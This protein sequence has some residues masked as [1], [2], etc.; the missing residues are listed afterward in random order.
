MQISDPLE[1]LIEC[2]QAEVYPCTSARLLLDVGWLV[3]PIDADAVQ[4]IDVVRPD[5]SVLGP[6]EFL[7]VSMQCRYSKTQSQAQAQAQA[8]ARALDQ[9]ILQ[10]VVPEAVLDRTRIR[11]GQYEFADQRQM[12]VIGLHVSER[13]LNGDERLD[14]FT[15]PKTS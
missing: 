9:S 2:I 13:V 11:L 3:G 15:R 14:K 10:K 7:V 1:N 8:Q 5:Q 6:G 12:S 4:R